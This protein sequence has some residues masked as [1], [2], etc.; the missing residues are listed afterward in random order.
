MND[1]GKTTDIKVD[2]AESLWPKLHRLAEGYKEG[3]DLIRQVQEL[4]REI[5]SD[6]DESGVYTPVFEELDEVFSPAKKPYATG[7]TFKAL[8][9]PD[10]RILTDGLL[11]IGAEANTG[12]TTLMTALAVDL[13]ANN[14]N[15]CALVYSLDD[16]GTMTKRRVVSQIV[17]KSLF[18]THTVPRSE[19][20][21]ADEQVLKRIYV[22][23]TIR[24]NDIEREALRIKKATGCQSIYIGIDY[25]QIIP[26]PGE[27]GGVREGLNEV[28]KRLK[29][30]QKKL[31]TEGCLL[32][33]LS[34]LNRPGNEEN[35]YTMSRFRETSEIENQA[36]IALL[37]F[38]KDSNPNK[39]DNRERKI[40]V[41]K[42]KKGSRGRWWKTSLVRGHR[43]SHWEQFDP[44]E[45]K[46]KAGGS[47]GKQQTPRESDEQVSKKPNP[48]SGPEDWGSR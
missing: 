35:P 18:E 45:E 15:M 14:A 21:A 11:V 19:L 39:E 32:V 26:L 1:Y 22:R 17:G 48:Y 25:L 10:Y 23:D 12:K 13:L 30:I 5:E 27:K 3:D 8:N 29:E 6:F 46:R 7:E 43:F 34:Q 36:D 41:V 40:M 47:N 20:T 31:S 44:K 16:G 37:M 24:V 9:H 28:V 2:M 42:N 4:V 38:P 33:L